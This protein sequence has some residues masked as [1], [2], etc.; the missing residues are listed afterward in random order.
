MMS[1][2][3]RVKCGI[4]E[5]ILLGKASII[6]RMPRMIPF[7]TCLAASASINST[8]LAPDLELQPRRLERVPLAQ[9]RI[10]AAS[11]LFA[12]MPTIARTELATS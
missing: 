10:G 8:R 1:R 4:A 6:C 3:A 2:S 11:R 9:R 7:Q 5:E 12:Q